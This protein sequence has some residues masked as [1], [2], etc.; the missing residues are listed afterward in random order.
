MCGTRVFRCLVPPY[1]VKDHL[2]EE[3]VD[4]PFKLPLGIQF[5]CCLLKA[6]PSRVTGQLVLDEVGSVD[7]FVQRDLLI[8]TIAT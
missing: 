3:P 5:D 7:D 2:V 6:M 8:E 4:E 1:E